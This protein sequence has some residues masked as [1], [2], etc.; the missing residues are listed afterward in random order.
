MN[1][2]YNATCIEI[3]E[4]YVIHFNR[5]RMMSRCQD[6]ANDCNVDVTEVVNDVDT[7]YIAEF[8]DTYEQA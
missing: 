8:G 7:L 5:D 3:V 4:D 1:E 2:Y 6:L